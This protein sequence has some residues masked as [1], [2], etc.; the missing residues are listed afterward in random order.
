MGLVADN[1]PIFQC[2]HALFDRINHA[3]VVRR[4]DDGRTEIVDLLEDL[5]DFVSVDRIQISRWL[6]GDD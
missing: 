1:P 5:D 2:H 3:F 6:V 4:E